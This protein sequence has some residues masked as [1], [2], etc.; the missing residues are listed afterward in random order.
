MTHVLLYIMDN[1]KGFMYYDERMICTVWC[2]IY[3]KY[4]RFFIVWCTIF[5]MYDARCMLYV[6]DARRQMYDV[7]HTM[8]IVWK[9][10]HGTCCWHTVYKVCCVAYVICCITFILLTM[11]FD[12]WCVVYEVWR[13]TNDV[14]MIVWFMIRV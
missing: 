11:T 14:C 1:V 6:S 7:R 2:I 5:A 9:M 13:M 8:N 4:Y 12:V 3:Y 10:M